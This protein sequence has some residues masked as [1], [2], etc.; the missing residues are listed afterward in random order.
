LNLVK[1]LNIAGDDNVVQK[2]NTLVFTGDKPDKNFEVKLGDTISRDPAVVGRSTVVVDGTCGKWT[3]PELV[4]KVSWPGSGRVPE[5][6]FLEKACAEAKKTTG[7]WAVK[8]L[9]SMLH[10]IDVGFDPKSTLEA[11]AHLFQVGELIGGKFVYERRTLRVIIQER[12]YSLKALKNVKDIGQAF[13]DIAC[14]MCVRFSSRVPYAYTGSVHRW[15]LDVPGILHRDLSFNNIMYRTIKERNGRGE[16]E[17][18][19]GV[20]TDY[21]LSSW[22]V[23]L[24]NDYTKTSQQR[25][26]TPPYMA[27]ELLKGTSDIHLYRHDIESLFYIMLLTCARHKFDYSDGAKWSVVMR[28]GRLPYEKW[29][30]EQDYDTLGSHKI[31]FFS[32]IEPVILSPA[33][34]GF[35]GW[36]QDLRLSFTKGYERRI[37]YLAEQQALP[38]WRQ[39]RAGSS[40][41][42]VKPTPV[43]FDDET[44]GGYVDYSAVIEPTRYLEGDLKG[45]TIR[46]D[47]P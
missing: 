14:S 4:V 45:I 39:K 25:T 36:L 7:Q 20:L 26:G 38:E 28:D 11:V 32:Q 35:R 27:Q 6:A 18:I 9:P 2:G 47:I 15:L 41:G 17:Y 10:A 8:H 3:K 16:T 46:Y 43:S 37:S 21:D 13:L 44:L 33:F 1:N 19:C 22:A 40:T 24:R 29:F 42:Q 30:N 31:A 12:L 5:T 23:S 34:E